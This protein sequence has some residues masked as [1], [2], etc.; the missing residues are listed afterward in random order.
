MCGIAGVFGGD[1]PASVFEDLFAD[2]RHRGPDNSGIYR[3]SLVKLG[4]NRLRFRGSDIR[5]PIR[6]DQGVAAFNGQVYGYFDDNG[7][8]VAVPDGLLNELSVP[9]RRGACTDGM[10]AY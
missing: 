9:E 8:H 2:I 10:Y 6:T 3:D 5:L 4:M 1:S 7:E